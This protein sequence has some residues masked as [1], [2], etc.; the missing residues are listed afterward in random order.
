MIARL[1]ME[2]FSL[3]DLRPGFSKKQTPAFAFAH[4]YRVV[5]SAPFPPDPFNILQ[6]ENAPP[7]E[8]Y[9][10]AIRC[11][12]SEDDQYSESYGALDACWRVLFSNPPTGDAARRKRVRDM[13][14]QNSLIGVNGHLERAN[15]WIHLTGAALFLVFATARPLFLNTVSVAG[16]LSGITSAVVMITFLVSTAYHALGTLD[17]LM[18]ILRTLDHGSIYVALAVAT[19][20]DTA[21]V[22]LDFRNVPWQT[23]SDA[24]FVAALL[25][26]FFSYRRIVLPASATVVAWGS[27][28]LGLFR[29]SHADKEHSAMRSSGY[30]I[31]SFGFISLIP[32]TVQNLSYEM[33]VILLVCNA[34]SLLLLI[35]G[36]LLDNALVWPDSMYEEGKLPSCI[37]HS[38]TFCN[39]ILC[40]SHAIWHALSLLSVII[41]T[42]GREIVISATEE[43]RVGG[44]LF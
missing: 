16:A 36:L 1:K 43:T 8:S 37:C 26:V 19:V 25:L 6:G 29:L 12:G 24:I 15:A 7:Q 34:T 21:V 33:A 18:P 9:E 22:T 14:L 4:E 27:C 31:L 30:V 35:G 17:A 38:K 41:L 44:S 3:L 5:Q 32:A 20:T 23:I 13:R 28:K 2:K 11:I 39:G 40:N 42:T 10:N